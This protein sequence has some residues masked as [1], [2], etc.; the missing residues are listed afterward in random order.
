MS[1]NNLITMNVRPEEKLNSNSLS[2]Y[3]IVYS[4]VAI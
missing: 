4:S 1:K 2:F 3:D